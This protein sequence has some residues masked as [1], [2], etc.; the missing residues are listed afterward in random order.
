M[1]FPTAVAV[2]FSIATFVNHVQTP[3]ADKVMGSAAV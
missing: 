1:S 2:F 3:P